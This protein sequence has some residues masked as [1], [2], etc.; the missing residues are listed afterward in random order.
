MI[1]IIICISYIIYVVSIIG[2]VLSYLEKD[3]EAGCL[4]ILLVICPVVNTVIFILFV[5][6]KCKDGRSRF[7]SMNDFLFGKA[8]ETIRKIFTNNPQHQ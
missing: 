6:S 7:Q 1:G 2:T 3:I 8:K 4:S 5:Y